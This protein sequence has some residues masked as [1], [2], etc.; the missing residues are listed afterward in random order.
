MVVSTTKLV[1]PIDYSSQGMPGCHMDLPVD[2]VG[3]L[4]A[5]GAVVQPFTRGAGDA[6]ATMTWTPPPGSAGQHVYIQVVV[7][8]PGENLGGLLSTIVAELWIG[9]S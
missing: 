1:T 2:W 6:A 5:S 3:V 9:S 7:G 8:A 4:P